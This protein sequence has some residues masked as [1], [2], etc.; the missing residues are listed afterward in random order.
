[1]K[2]RPQG[3]KVQA[4]AYFGYDK[5][6]KQSIIKMVATYDPYTFDVSYVTEKDGTE[7]ATSEMKNEITEHLKNIK[8][9][10]EEK[11]ALG[12]F[13]TA[14]Y[15]L[16][17][18]GKLL[19]ENPDLAGEFLKDRKYSE[20]EIA[21]VWRALQSLEKRLEAEGHQRPKRQYKKP[22]DQK[23]PRQVDLLTKS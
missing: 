15:T 21:G 17:K 11:S 16:G 19:E 5:E 1:M 22:A 23:D 4:L 3:N 7:R 6:K 13:S 10:R 20:Q 2:F 9:E 12:N 18:C 14:I 8:A